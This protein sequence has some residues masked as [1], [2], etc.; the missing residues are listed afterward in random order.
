MKLQKDPLA[1]EFPLEERALVEKQKQIHLKWRVLDPFGQLTLPG[2]FRKR[3]KCLP[4]CYTDAGH[5][6]GFGLGSI[7]RGFGGPPA[8]IRRRDNMNRAV[9]TDPG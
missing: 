9:E 4:G 2:S 6:Q 7:K 1:E 8:R 5:G 3:A